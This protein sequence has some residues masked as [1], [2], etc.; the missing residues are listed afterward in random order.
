[1]GHRMT[2]LGVRVGWLLAAALVSIA[3]VAPFVAV[4][5]PD[6]QFRDHTY[7]PPMWPHVTDEQGGWHRPFVYPLRLVNRLEL[8]FE[9]D[10]S[11]RLPLRW[12]AG[13]RLVSVDPD[14]GPWLPLGGD[15][16]GRDVY[17][18]LMH[19]AQLS[20]GVSLIATVAALALGAVVG[21]FA[22]VA[23]GRSETLLMTIADFFIV[24]PVIYVVLALR[25][26][27]PLVLTTAA[28]FWATAAILGLVGWPFAAR[29][30][31]AVVATE[32][33]REYAE[34]AR[35]AGASRSRILLRHLL[36]AARG[37]LAVQASLLVP[38]FI[39]AEATLSFVGLGFS[40]P[41][42]SWGGML[43]DA[44]RGRAFTDAPWL[45]SPALTIAIS[46]LSVQ[47]LARTPHV[48]SISR[49]KSV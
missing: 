40:E 18:R 28:I 6:Q 43:R 49:R 19:G 39:M 33:S 22:G 44:G 15:A 21:A 1:M 20:L 34:S 12:L 29:A 41:S 32:K 23:G 42:V 2:P 11:Q 3:V 30:V 17:S 24:L 31:R 10:R 4:N 7:A 37:V 48:F 8:R 45:L 9:E 35:A 13:G 5:R 27:M 26:A 16:L 47:L 14:D 38:A 36:P 25:A 46:I